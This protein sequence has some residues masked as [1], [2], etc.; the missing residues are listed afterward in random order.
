MA[1]CVPT[2]HRRW[3]AKRQLSY[4]HFVSTLALVVAIGGGGAAVA[5]GLAK[6]SVGSPQV[7]N[8]TISSQDLR[9]GRV[10]GRDVNE[11]S[12]DR[13]PS[14]D[15]AT[16]ADNSL[17]AA[18]TG[19]G[20]LERFQSQGALSASRIDEGKYV[21]VFERPVKACSYLASISRHEVGPVENGRI[22]VSLNNDD[23]RALN[24]ET[25]FATAIDNI[26]LS[27]TLLVLC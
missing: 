12:L 10:T 9:D 15:T 17:A 8:N 20:L 2:A 4:P 16:R 14:A 13:V 18:V 23:P 19:D 27:F 26:N 5:A 7:K 22:G 3:R 21:V 1:K 24:V 25:Y 11:R 6:N